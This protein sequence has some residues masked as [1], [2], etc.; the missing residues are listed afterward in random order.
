MRT[1][2]RRLHPHKATEHLSP[3]AQLLLQ[4]LEE[5]VHFPPRTLPLG[6]RG[7]WPGGGP[8]GSSDPAPVSLGP[9]PGRAHEVAQARRP[10]GNLVTSDGPGPRVLCVLGVE[11]GL[12]EEPSAFQGRH[13]VGQGY[14]P[15]LGGALH[16][17]SAP[18]GDPGHRGSPA[19]GSRAG[20]AGQGPP[21]EAGTRSP[22]SYDSF[23]AAPR[24]PMGRVPAR[25][26]SPTV[27]SV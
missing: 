22:L 1:Q 7:G 3:G 19:L 26:H 24:T 11:G 13:P 21:Q 10:T 9:L 27:N 5:S 6:T 16:F 23:P 20:A 4:P 18:Q 8:Q 14:S 25:T 15:G 17:P 12:R 2:L